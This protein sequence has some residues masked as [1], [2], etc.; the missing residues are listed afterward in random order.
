MRTN[1][2]GLLTIPYYGCISSIAL[3]PMRKKPLFHYKPDKNIVSVGQFGC[4]MH[5][6]FCQNSEISQY[7]PTMSTHISPDE[8]VS[9]GIREKERNNVGIAFTYNEP[10][11]GY[12]FVYDT[13]KKAKENM[14]DVVLVTNGMINKKPM[15]K[16]APYIDAMNIDL[17][18]FD[19]EQYKSMGGELNTVLS[20]IELA[21]E[22]K[23]HIEITYLA[24]PRAN[25]M[26]TE[27]EMISSFIKKLDK[28]IPLHINKY[29]PRFKMDAKA[30]DIGLL[31]ELESIAKNTLSN[32][33]VGNI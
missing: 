10:L 12:E 6:S 21:F 30:T 1:T 33:Y 11:V 16:L 27:I 22:S 23:I 17:K 24:F 2:N 18:C 28:D 7:I 4:N 29:Y 26:K 20:T 19:R 9:I 32:V 14:L 13:A 3:D 15:R 8:L 5:C 25:D 31:R